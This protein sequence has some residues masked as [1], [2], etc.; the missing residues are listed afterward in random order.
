MGCLFSFYDAADTATGK[1]AACRRGSANARMT[2]P[3]PA[4]SR[5]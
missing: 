4:K 5:D 1:L 2:L 3:N